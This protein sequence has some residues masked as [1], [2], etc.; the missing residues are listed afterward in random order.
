[1]RILITT[2]AFP[3]NSGGSGWSTYE[4]ARGLRAA[5]HDIFLVKPYSEPDLAPNDYDGFSV[6]GF[7]AFAP[8]ELHAQ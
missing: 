1:M 3:P 8:P 6:K 7:P 5:G 4:L 2:D